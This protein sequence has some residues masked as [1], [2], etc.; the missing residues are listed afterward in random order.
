MPLR[1]KI[2]AE[3]RERSKMSADLF[4]LMIFLIVCGWFKACY[5]LHTYLK[6]HLQVKFLREK[7]YFSAM[8]KLV[9]FGLR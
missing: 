2:C 5:N 8:C 6:D 4:V 3:W 7:Y 9:S 1:I